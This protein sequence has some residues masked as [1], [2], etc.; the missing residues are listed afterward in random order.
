MALPKHVEEAVDRLEEAS[1]RIEQARA[2][3]P[4]MQS[5]HEWL[6][7]LTD[8]VSAVSTIHEL[9]REAIQEK[10]DEVAGRLRLEPRPGKG[11]RAGR[12]P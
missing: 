8:F 10:L 7:A 3:R 6:T 11:P 1:W 12:P 4:T 5:L 2:K 9:D